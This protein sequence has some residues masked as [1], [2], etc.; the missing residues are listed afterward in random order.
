MGGVGEGSLSAG[1]NREWAEGWPSQ[2]QGFSLLLLKWPVDVLWGRPHHGPRRLLG[3]GSGCASVTCWL[4]ASPL[5]SQDLGVL[6]CEMHNRSTDLVA[7][8]QGLRETAQQHSASVWPM[9]SAERTHGSLVLSNHSRDTGHAAKGRQRRATSLPE[10]SGESPRGSCKPFACPGRHEQGLAEE[11]REAQV[12]KLRS[13]SRLPGLCVVYVYVGFLPRAW[14]MVGAHCLFPSHRLGTQW[15]PN[16]YPPVTWMGTQWV[17][18][19]HSLRDWPMGGVRCTLPSHKTWHAAMFNTASV[20]LS[21]SHPLQQ[22][23]LCLLVVTLPLA[24]D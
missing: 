10:R 21:P 4:R 17:L 14:F 7:G 2:G 16:A 11:A 1:T 8:W 3:S 13:Q 24:Q 15:V 6:S 22:Q 23:G 19:A 9:G 5:A 12:R 20:S 18:E